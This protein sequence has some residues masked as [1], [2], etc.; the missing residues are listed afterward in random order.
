MIGL[1]VALLCVFLTLG[2][3]AGD[4]AVAAQTAQMQGEKTIQDP[5]VQPDGWT[6]RTQFWRQAREG[7]E[8][9]VNQPRDGVLI[10]R[11]GT[12][13]RQVRTGLVSTYGEQLVVVASVALLGVLLL[14][15][16]RLR[17]F[18]LS[19]ATQIRRLGR[20]DRFA[21]WLTAISFLLLGSTGLV[22]LYGRRMIAPIFGR[23]AFS[24][25][26]MVS[27]TIHDNVSWAFM[28]GVVLL[29]MIWIRDHV[30]T[31]GRVL[32][33]VVAG[34][35]LPKIT[36][37]GAT[38]KLVFWS[39]VAGGLVVC[40]S[41]LALL[42]PL[43]FADMQS[44]QLMQVLHSLSSMTLATLIFGH[45]FVATMS[46]RENT[47]KLLEAKE[48]LE[49]RVDERT[50]EL[51]QLNDALRQE[52]GERRAVEIRLGEAMATAEEANHTKDRFLAAASHDL[53]QPLSAARLMIAILQLRPMVD[54]DR[55]LVDRV[56]LAL[57][58][59]EDLLSD[60]LDIS[61]LDARGV[62]P[63]IT[64]V[65]AETFIHALISEF[66]T[67]ALRA[68]LHLQ[69][70][71]CSLSVRTDSHL[72]MRVLRNF[73]SNA[74]R[75]TPAGRV[76]VGCRRRG[77]HLRFEVWDTGLGIPEDLLDRIFQEFHRA[78]GPA[79]LQE[80]ASGLGLAIVDRI[81]RILDHRITLRSV[82]GRGSVF[83]VEI[84]IALESEMVAEPA[85]TF[86]DDLAGLSVLVLD[87]DDG[88]LMGMTSL[89][90]EW[91][92]LVSPFR[93]PENA[94][95]APEL[96]TAELL[97]VD[98]HLDNLIGVQFVAE[99]WRR[100]GR[101]PTIIVSADRSAEVRADIEAHGLH[102]LPKPIKPAMLR[103][104]MTHLRSSEEEEE[105]ADEAKEVAAG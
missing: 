28:L 75:Y 46:I 87:N 77:D 86:E 6:G 81:A 99:A 55:E 66:E 37:F 36:P 49:R 56:H 8:G 39:V 9:A 94:L 61:K 83:A 98:Y 51:S 68:G 10:Q 47:R 32:K 103:A 73:L 16:S 7:V 18:A 40:Y 84:P 72:L 48:V 5:G 96:A 74:I 17:S 19:L 29:V 85:P 69:G 57:T 63:Q 88:V 26:A 95:D 79:N 80:R 93:T 45:I 27:K 101:L 67:M 100:V 11:H 52:I 43:V 54:A 50:H 21:H 70:V 14:M 4:F 41:G 105:E 91:G 30:P 38:E 64:V 35:Q 90:E 92:C 22:I 33:S 78:G 34:G 12:V 3:Q 23:D 20:I 13:W 60:L 102:L 82:V 104:L 42:F 44:M 25:I 62:V 71:G 65:P 76:L 58:G 89:I 31:A 59:A 2:A 1:A 97:I 24:S 15:H 53:L